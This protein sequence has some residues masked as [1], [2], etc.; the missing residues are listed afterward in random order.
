MRISEYVLDEDGVPRRAYEGEEW[1]TWFA[2]KRDKFSLRTTIEAGEH[3]IIVSTVFLAL[4]HNHSGQGNPILW[5]TLAFGGAANGGDIMNRCGG[6]FEDA[7]AMHEEMCRNIRT[8]LES[9][10][11]KRITESTEE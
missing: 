1:I 11:P 3:F 7:A 4:D 6:T 5:E 2:S 10:P 9:N 8:R